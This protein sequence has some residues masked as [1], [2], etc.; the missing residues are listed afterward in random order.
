[1]PWV[2][3]CEWEYTSPIDLL[4]KS[5]RVSVVFQRRVGEGFALNATRQ[6]ALGLIERYKGGREAEVTIDELALQPIECEER[7]ST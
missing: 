6:K 1:M 3:R 7:E 2:Y 5:V 4:R